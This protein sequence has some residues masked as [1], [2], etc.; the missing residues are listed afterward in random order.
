MKIEK[1][2]SLRNHNTFGINVSAGKYVEIYDEDELK[3]LL[4]LNELKDKPKLILGGGSNILFT[5][6]YEGIVIKNLIPGI[7]IIFEG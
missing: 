3:Q 5:H 4:S 2:K 7:K 6:D 1:N